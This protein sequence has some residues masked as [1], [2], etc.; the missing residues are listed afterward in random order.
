MDC[1]GGND[2]DSHICRGN[3]SAGNYSNTFGNLKQQ[4]PT[5]GLLIY[6]NPNSFKAEIN[7]SL[8]G[9]KP[10]IFTISPMTTAGSAVKL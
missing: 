9:Q 4:G 3:D 5:N 2:F 6:S 8:L 7:D 1:Q 10:I